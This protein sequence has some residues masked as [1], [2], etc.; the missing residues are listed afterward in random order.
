MDGEGKRAMD[1]FSYVA[2]FVTIT[3]A[4]AVG[5]LVQSLHRLVRARRK[6]RWHATPML[7]AAFVFFTV[8]S[9]F[10]SLWQFHDIARLGYYELVA[11]ISVAVLF[12]MAACAA[13]PED[14]PEA[15]L[16]LHAFYLDNRRYFYVVLALAFAG[17]FLRGML[18]DWKAGT[19]IADGP[20]AGVWTGT[21]FA[22]VLLLAVTARPR[23]H[24][25]GVLLLLGLAHMG[26]VHWAIVPPGI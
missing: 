11:L 23:L 22:L 17:D 18:L 4:L 21:T 8:L 14:V 20:F 26:Y 19:T 24:L 7:A 2:A 1:L 12:A 9:E 25:A 15:G 6:V 10:F 3:L 13:L 16:D 5:D